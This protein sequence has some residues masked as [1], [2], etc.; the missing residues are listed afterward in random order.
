MPLRIYADNTTAVE[1]LDV[2][3]KKSTSKINCVTAVVASES[4]LARALKITGLPQYRAV[5]SFHGDTAKHIVSNW[6]N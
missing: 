2:E 4:E 6:F 3:S 5:M 1:V